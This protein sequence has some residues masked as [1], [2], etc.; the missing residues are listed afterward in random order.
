MQKQTFG[1]VGTTGK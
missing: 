1:E